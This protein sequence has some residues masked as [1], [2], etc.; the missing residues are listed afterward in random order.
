M[1]LRVAKEDS[2]LLYQLLEAYEGLANYSTLNSE[3]GLGFR[4]I[5]LYPAPDMQ[6]DLNLALRGIAKEV[7]FQILTLDSTLSS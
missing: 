3:K 1:I 6:E 7:C 2:V 5:Q 4:D